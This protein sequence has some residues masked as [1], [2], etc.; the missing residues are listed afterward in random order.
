[1]QAQQSEK[2][3]VS[4]AIERSWLDVLARLAE[5]RRRW[6]SDE[7]RLSIVRTLI[8]ESEEERSSA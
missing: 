2:V 6:L 4:V 7:L 3:I 5:E 8:A 1:M